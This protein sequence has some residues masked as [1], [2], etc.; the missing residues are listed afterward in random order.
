MENLG[1][2]IAMDFAVHRFRLIFDV[3]LVVS[4]LLIENFPLHFFVSVIHSDSH[5]CLSYNIDVIVF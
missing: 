1:F 2:L 4:C 5:C 3:M